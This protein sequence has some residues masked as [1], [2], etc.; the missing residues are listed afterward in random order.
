MGVLKYTFYSKV[1]REQ[2]NCMLMLPSYEPWRHPEGEK[3]YYENYGKKKTLYILHGGSDDSS[4]YLRRT[5]IEEYAAS[6]DLAVVFPEVRNSFYCNMIH[7]KEYFTYLS[8]ELPEM[9]ERIFPLSNKREERFVLG[10]SMGSHGAFKWAL[11]R[12]DFFAAAAGM[13]G[14]GDLEE[15]GFYD[16]Q[17]NVI[18]PVYDE[19]F[20]F[21]E[22]LALVEL[23][24][25]CG[26]ID[27]ENNVVIPFDYEAGLSF[28]EGFA[29]AHEDYAEGGERCFRCY[30]L[31]LLET[32]KLAREKQ[33][34]FFTTTLSISPLK[35]ADKLNE[36][37]LQL[38]QEYEVPYLF[39]DFKKKNG[40]K[41]ST[42]LSR[43]YGLYRQDYCGCVFSMRERER[44]REKQ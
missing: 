17:K 26:F 25:K 32:A 7:G 13:S 12:P 39:S 34:D 28:S 36:I 21:K 42:E 43:E 3:A 41:R 23:D 11:N 14:A 35:R 18:P 16:G 40:Y 20:S 38:Q 37:G 5:R 1:L 6:R 30:R 15:L 2:T 33:F 19:V 4:L 8:E 29:M 9:L 24:E 31:R 10:N 22:G 44:E 27:S